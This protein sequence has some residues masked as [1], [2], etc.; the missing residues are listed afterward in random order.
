MK[1]FLAQILTALACAAAAAHAASPNRTLMTTAPRAL[2]VTQVTAPDGR[3]ELRAFVGPVLNT[4]IGT[5]NVVGAADLSPAALAKLLRAPIFKANSLPDL[6]YDPVT[7]GRPEL[8]VSYAVSQGYLSAADDTPIREVL[9]D[10]IRHEDYSH[11]YCDEYSCYDNRVCLDWHEVSGHHYCIKHLPWPSYCTAWGEEQGK[12]ICTGWM[13]VPPGHRVVA[14]TTKN[15]Q[16]WGSQ[17]AAL[18]D[19]IVQRWIRDEERRLIQHFNQPQGQSPIPGLPAGR[20]LA[21]YIG[22]SIVNYLKTNGIAN[23]TYRYEQ[24]LKMPATGETWQLFFDLR[25]SSNGNVSYGNARAVPLDLMQRVLVMRYSSV[26]KD[27]DIPPLWSNSSNPHGRTPGRLSWW[28]EENNA[29]VEPVQS[30]DFPNGKFDPPAPVDEDS[31]APPQDSRWAIRCLLLGPSA[32]ADCPSDAPDAQSLMA[33]KRA[34]SALLIYDEPLEDQGI[35]VPSGTGSNG[36]PAYD[37]VPSVTTSISARELILDIVSNPNPGPPACFKV[38]KYR[39][40]GTWQAKILDKQRRYVIVRADPTIVERSSTQHVLEDANS[41]SLEIPVGGKL[42]DYVDPAVALAKPEYNGSS[43][44]YVES[45]I[46]KTGAEVQSTV[47]AP[48]AYTYNNTTGQPVV[49][50]PECD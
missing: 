6:L 10:P 4:S 16:T 49:S 29:Q 2:T 24:T 5:T 39:E 17:P 46:D 12:Q 32:S 26:R 25:A 1:R 41:Y 23:G 11:R 22:Q 45:S 30:V 20:P 3:S 33:A 21:W 27:E 15:L 14:T 43:F 19:L 47:R 38:V 28:I 7:G 44:S 36:Q 37:T 8:L 13:N 31:S 9:F 40:S 42:A 34:G 50:P 18:R 48:L 35:E